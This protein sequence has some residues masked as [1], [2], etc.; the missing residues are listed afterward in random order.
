[1]MTDLETTADELEETECKK[2]F[3]QID[4]RPASTSA[5]APRRSC[6]THPQEAE[7][8]RTATRDEISFRDHESY[9][10]Q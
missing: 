3:K 1:M 7:P 8:L 6:H 4:D 10:G 5:E 9:T 2:T